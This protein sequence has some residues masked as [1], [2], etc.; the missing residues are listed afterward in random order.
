MPP[1]IICLGGIITEVVV[2]VESCQ[3]NG[4]KRPLINRAKQLDVPTKWNYLKNFLVSSKFLLHTHTSQ[5]VTVN[6]PI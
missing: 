6:E 5:I 1:F 3:L 2:V 4:N